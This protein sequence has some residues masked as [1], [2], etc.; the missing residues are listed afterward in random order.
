MDQAK[1]E[2]VLRLIKMMTGNINYSVEE[3]ARRLDISPRS[4]YRYIDTFKEAGFVV[5]K[6]NGCYSLAKE[7]PYFKQISQLIH[8]TDEE[9]HIVGKLIDGIDDTNVMKQNLRRK[10]SSVYNCTAVADTIV[11]GKNSSN[12]HAIIEAIETKKQVLL[13]D[14]GSSSKGTVRDRLVEPFG[15]TTNYV[16]IWCYDLEDG[17]N[18]LFNTSR[19]GSV[20]ACLGD[21]EHEDEHRQGYIDIFRFSGYQRHRVRLELGLMARNLIIEEYPLAEKDLSRIG[22]G[23][24]LLDTELCNYSGMCRFY[25]GLAQDIRIVDSPEFA[26]YVRKYVDEQ[27]K[28]IDDDV[29]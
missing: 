12:V 8:F 25:V 2:R 17:K 22:E 11:K 29:V 1:I 7:S 16:Q 28:H 6:K 5:N 4:I 27:L 18:K 13:K 23:K 3:M 21:W 10:L 9:A 15:F 26:A 20:E 14:Y 24:W 19:I